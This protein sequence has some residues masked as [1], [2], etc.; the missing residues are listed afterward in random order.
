[1]VYF[2]L[3]NT[4]LKHLTQTFDRNDFYEIKKNKYTSSYE[5]AIIFRS[6]DKK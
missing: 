4:S 3:P 1:M 2:T 6:R 5:G